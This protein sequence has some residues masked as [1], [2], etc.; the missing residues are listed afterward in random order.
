MC[1]MNIF[2]FKI[3]LLSIIAKITLFEILFCQPRR[4]PTALD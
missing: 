1:K 4:T 3:L 2:I